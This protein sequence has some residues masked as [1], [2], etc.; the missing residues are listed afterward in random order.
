M[1]WIFGRT[2]AWTLVVT[3]WSITPLGAEPTTPAPEPARRAAPAAPTPESEFNRGLRAQTAKEWN[4]AAQA[5]RRAV[6][7]RP[8]YAE[9]WN[10]LGY[11]LRNQGKYQD[12]LKAYDEALRLRPNFP[13]ALEYLGEAYVKLGRLDD[14]RRILERLRP[15]DAGRARELADEIAKAR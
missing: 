8:A 13:E 5:Y 2:L 14:A 15:L 1:S 12:S 7:L 11:A 9:A 6:E 4:T 3:T 10:G